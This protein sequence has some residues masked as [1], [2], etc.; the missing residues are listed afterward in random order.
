M[1]LAV[2]TPRIDAQ[3]DNLRQFEFLCQDQIESERKINLLAQPIPFFATT[4]L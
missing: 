4:V 3:R 1:Q 2:E